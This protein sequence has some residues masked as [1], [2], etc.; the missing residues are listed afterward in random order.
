MSGFLDQVTTV[1]YTPQYAYSSNKS[2][3][4]MKPSLILGYQCDSGGRIVEL[5][6]SLVGDSVPLLIVAGVEVC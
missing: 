2:L 1:C 3:Q 5:D 6:S 4:K